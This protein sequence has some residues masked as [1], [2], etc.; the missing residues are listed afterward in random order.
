MSAY[1]VIYLLK[2]HYEDTRR[3]GNGWWKLKWRPIW[4]QTYSIYLTK[5]FNAYRLGIFCYKSDANNGW[6]R[7][8]KHRTLELFFLNLGLSFWIRYDFIVHKDGPG[9]MGYSKPLVLPQK[10]L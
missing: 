4:R 5:S 2:P 3:G 10:A 7:H 6:N 8:Y 9:D 1:D